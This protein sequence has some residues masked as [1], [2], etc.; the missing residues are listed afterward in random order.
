MQSWR[1][2]ASVCLNAHKR[3]VVRETTWR[4]CGD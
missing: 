3:H 2:Q 4:L 1:A